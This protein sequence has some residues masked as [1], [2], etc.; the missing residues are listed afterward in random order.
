MKSLRN[1][2]RSPM[3]KLSKLKRF[4]LFGLFAFRAAWKMGY[5]EEEARLLGYST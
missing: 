3:A 4:S 5:P 1:E 2:E